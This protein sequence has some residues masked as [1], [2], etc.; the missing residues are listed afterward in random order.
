MILNH[1]WGLYTHP[2]Q[3]WQS[4]EQTHEGVGASLA[5]ILIIALIPTI[6]GF[7][8]SS[9]IGWSIGAGDPIKLTQGSAAKMAVAM[10]AALIAGVFL[11]AYLAH[12]MAKTF[13]AKPSFTQAIELSAYTATPLFMVGFATLYPELWFVML[14]GL[15]GIAYSVYLLYSGVPII[16]N[17]P[18]ERGFIYASSLV[19]CGLVL[20]V[21]I[22]A[23]SVILW[24][25]GFGPSY[26]G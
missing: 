24:N 17:I 7:F 23:S 3:E 4:I 11:L 19:T 15:A 5:H 1:L 2:R 26:V 20:L 16:M 21:A 14:V 13:G 9:Y 12:W 22:L 25:L 8:A 10:Y 18:E 6:C